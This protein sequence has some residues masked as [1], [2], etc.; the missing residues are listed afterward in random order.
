MKYII[1]A[2]KDEALKRSAEIATA[3]GCGRNPE[4]VTRYWFAVIE[5]PK[6]KEGAMAIVDA[7]DESKLAAGE[8]TKLKLKSTLEQA[9]WFADAK[10]IDAQ[11]VTAET[12]ALLNAAMAIAK[13]EAKM[14][15]LPPT[16]DE[17]A[18]RAFIALVIVLAIVLAYLAAR[19]AGLVP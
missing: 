4:D 10:A 14:P 3:L 9:G 11:P 6:T 2:D 7:T 13:G 1:Y 15:Q 18:M 5:H 17:W 8:T 16:K 12:N 19:Y